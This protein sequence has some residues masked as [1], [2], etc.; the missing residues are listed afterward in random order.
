MLRS[1]FDNLSDECDN[2]DSLSEVSLVSLDTQYYNDN[3]DDDTDE[4]HVPSELSLGDSRE[5]H[6]E[7]A[8]RK[9]MHFQI[10][11]GWCKLD[12]FENLDSFKK[13]VKKGD[14]G[15]ILM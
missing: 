10:E 8:K 15:L 13:E 3:Q 1:E 12:D 11:H 5:M 14:I 9:R 4:I 7:L 2:S 6:A